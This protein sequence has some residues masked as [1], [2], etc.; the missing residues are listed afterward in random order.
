[1]AYEQKEGDISIFKNNNKE[2]DSQPDYTGSALINGQKMRVALWV[3][4][5]TKGK[6]FAGKVQEDTYNKN[7]ASISQPEPTDEDGL[8]F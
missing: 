3:K 5:G 4:E 2:K 8:P 7:Q 1:M 6:F